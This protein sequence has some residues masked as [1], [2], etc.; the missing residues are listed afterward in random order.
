MG[1]DERGVRE[2]V[3]C[4][5]P[6]CPTAIAHYHPPPS[7]TIAAFIHSPHPSPAVTPQ[8]QLTTFNHYPPWP[9]PTHPAPPSLP[10][11]PQASPP[12]LPLPSPPRHT[13]F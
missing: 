5:A 1:L 10:R 6:T 11:P 9:T 2:G 4:T 8:Q 13:H 12:H 3:G 7:T